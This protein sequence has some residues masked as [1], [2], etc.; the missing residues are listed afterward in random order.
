MK[1]ERSQEPQS[2]PTP[3]FLEKTEKIKLPEKPIQAESPFHIGQVVKV[4]RHSGEVQ[5]DWSVLA[6]NLKGE[7]GKAMAFVARGA[8]TRRVY[9]ADLV[10]WQALKPTA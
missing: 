2:E 10:Q 3:S 1:F 5:H 8:E 9:E 6:L 4:L 7:N